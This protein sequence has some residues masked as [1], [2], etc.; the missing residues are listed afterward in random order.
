MI[1]ALWGAVWRAGLLIIL[2]ELFCWTL[3]GPEIPDSDTE[4]LPSYQEGRR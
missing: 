1:R 3:F 4:R 2:A